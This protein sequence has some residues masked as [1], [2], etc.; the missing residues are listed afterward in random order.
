ME[1]KLTTPMLVVIL[2]A[3]ALMFWLYVPGFMSFLLL[4]DAPLRHENVLEGNLPEPPPL[5]GALHDVSSRTLIAFHEYS[6]GMHKI[7]GVINKPTP[8]HRLEHVV[9]MNSEDAAQAHISFTLEDGADSEGGAC[10][11][12]I[13]Q[14]NFTVLF[15]A[16]PDI[17]VTA[18]LNGS[19][20]TLLFLEGEREELSTEI[21][22]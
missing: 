1:H 14:E 12:V 10:I 6:D 17:T 15:D 2:L 18:S 22:E 5:P 19:P 8:C 9:S 7:S 21:V 3:V 20:L 16:S 4:E 13:A 11:Q